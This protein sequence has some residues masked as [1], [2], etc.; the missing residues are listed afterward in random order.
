MQHFTRSAGAPPVNGYSHAVTFN[1]PMVAVS[2]QVPVDGDGNLV[3]KNDAEAQ[4]R[5]VYA[6]LSTALRAAGTDL[7]HVVKLTVYLTDL[8]DLAAF[9]RVR[10]E[11]QDAERPP[12]CSL[13]QVAG[14]VQPD[15]RVEIEAFAEV[16][17]PR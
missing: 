15:F 4:V 6:N 7:A 3:G 2:G 1:G 16:P 13:V 14:L 5:Q 10:D 12:A 9:R 8:G 17:E 11:H